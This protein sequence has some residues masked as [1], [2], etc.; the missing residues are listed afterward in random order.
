MGAVT[1]IKV[2]NVNN[3]V[4]FF[5]FNFAKTERISRENTAVK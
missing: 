3:N 4:F 5:F 1:K 2:D